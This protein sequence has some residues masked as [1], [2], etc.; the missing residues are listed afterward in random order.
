MIA[1]FKQKSP[2]NVALLLLFGLLLKLPMFLYP[3]TI[4]ASHIDGRFY[5]WLLSLLPPGNSALYSATAFTLLYIHALMINYMVNQYRLIIKATYL[6]AMAYLLITSLLPEW[7]YLSSPLLANTF[8]IWMFIY[9]FRLYNSNNA[10][11]Q[12]YNIGLITGMTSY[13]YFPSAAFI[14][15]ILLGLMILKPFRFNEVILLFLGCLTPYYFHA[16]YLFLFSKLNFANFFPHILIRMPAIKNSI[17]LAGSI[18]LLTIPFLIGGYY[19][20]ANL[21][22]MLIQVRKNWSVLL[23]YLLLA[24]FIPFINSDQSFHTWILI[25]V[26]FA[27]FHACAY[28]YPAK[29]WFPLLIFFI[30]TGYILYQQYGIL[31][32]Q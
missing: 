15:C 25:T 20:Q 3:K 13:I 8:I 18:L 28:F 23:I 30:T 9:L 27:A 12:V 31:T 17:W 32:W 2:G 11:A 26:P 6:P 19:V 22:R 1:L 5:Q 4:L 21:R 16:A 14:V 10:K 7:N 24:F 29:R